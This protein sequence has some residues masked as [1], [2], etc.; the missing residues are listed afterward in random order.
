MSAALGLLGCDPVLLNPILELAEDSLGITDFQILLNIP[1]PLT[2]AFQPLEHWTYRIYAPEDTAAAPHA[3]LLYAFGSADSRIKQIL[4]QAFAESL[5][6]QPARFASLRHPSAVIARSARLAAG[7]QIE[8]LV[9]ISACAE[10]AF[11]VNIKRNSSVGHHSQLGP[12]VTLNPGVTVNSS[13]SIGQGTRIGAGSVIR[14]HVRIGKNCL[15]G[16]GSVVTK[17]LPDHVIAFGNPCRIQREQSERFC[18]SL[19]SAQQ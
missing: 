11:G 1:V 12:F 18:I 8:S 14:D 16:M 4:Y 19:D 3:D 7:L 10:I 17:D 6:L 2:A 13:V 9:S 5:Q 15:I